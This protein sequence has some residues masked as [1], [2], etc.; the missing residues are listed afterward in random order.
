MKIKFII[1]AAAA[2]VLAAGIADAQDLKPVKDKATKL[3]GYQNKS[4]AWVIPP[5]YEGAKRF[6]DGLAE[7]SIK[8]GKT[9]YIGVIDTDGR[10]VIPLECS[11][12]SFSSKNHLIFAKRGD[13][14]NFAMWGVYDYGG[15]EIWPPQFRAAPSFTDGTAIV[16]DAYTGLKGVVDY[17]GHLIVPFE[18]LA[19]TRSH[20][21]YAVLT[22]D[23]V[24]IQY[25]GRLSTLSEYSHPGYVIPYDPDGDPVRAAAWGIWPIGTRF[26]SNSFKAAKV[27]RAPWQN[28]YC[29]DA[30]L[31]WSGERFVRIEPVEDEEVHPGSMIDPISGKLYTLKAVLY[32]ANGVPVGE[33]S[34]WGWIDAMFEEGAIYHGDDGQ[35]W[36]LMR[37]INYP[38]RPSFTSA[39]SF[40]KPVNHE[41]VLTGLGIYSYQLENM[42]NPLRYSDRAIKIITAENAGITYRV[43]APDPGFRYARAI[44]EIHRAPVFRQRFNCGDVFNCRVRPKDGGIELELADELVCRFDDRFNDPYFS[45]SEAVPIFWGP[46]ND[47]CVVLS[48]HPTVSS[49]ATKDDVYDTRGEFDIAL[50]LYDGRDRFVQTIALVPSVDYIADG[51]IV[52]EKEG[53]ALKMRGFGGRPGDKMGR[54]VKLEG[55]TRLPATISALVNAG[56]PHSPAPAQPTTNKPAQPNAGKPTPNPR[57]NENYRKNVEQQNAEQQNSGQQNQNAD[58]R[59]DEKQQQNT[60]PRRSGTR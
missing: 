52:L 55:A 41:N 8:E 26:H 53:I 9:K 15:N 25:D 33:V 30:G 29:S 35:V 43:P 51:W 23:F 14:D 2:L 7:V 16:E 13:E 56:R 18:N 19:V 48:A 6:K 5:S 37:D 58:Q 45:M 59:P 42:Y 46:H 32:E 44:Q 50:E 36:M 22:Q 39:L 10:I 24:H 34:E 38:A 57:H 21:G 12:V 60:P 54:I 47:Y 1:A 4:K 28:A 11:D 40:R 49:H 31:D 20:G 27:D 17:G 3:Y